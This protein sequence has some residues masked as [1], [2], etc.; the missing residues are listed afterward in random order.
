MLD[1]IIGQGKTLQG[2]TTILAGAI[3]RAAHAR[4]YEL[5]PALVVQLLG[6][7]WVAIGIGH[8]VW[9]TKQKNGVQL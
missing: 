1:K 6:T 5:D 9:R 8:K 3:I 2:V 4:G 7:V